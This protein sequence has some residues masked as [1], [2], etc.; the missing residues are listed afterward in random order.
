[1]NYDEIQTALANAKK[2]KDLFKSK[3]ADSGL[4]K[5][6]FSGEWEKVQPKDFEE[7][8]G[9][10]GVSWEDYKEYTTVVLAHITFCTDRKSTRLNSSHNVIS[11]MPSSA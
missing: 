7:K 10:K 2:N 8:L 9:K 4:F 11:R 5:R 3:I 6:G 1:M